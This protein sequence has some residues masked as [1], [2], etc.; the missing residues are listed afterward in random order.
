MLGFGIAAFGAAIRTGASWWDQPRSPRLTVLSHEEA[1]IFRS[2]ADTIFPGE[3]FPGGMPPAS[4]VGIVEFW[5][6]Y[7]A[8]VDTQTQR[9]L[10]LLT[11]AVDDGARL[12]DSRGLR[13]RDRPQAEREEILRAWDHSWFSAR[14][15][16]FT[17]LELFV[18]MGYTENP[19]VLEACGIEFMCATEPRSHASEP[20]G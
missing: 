1:E 18:A 7:L 19:R 20:I 3:K 16:A 4:E 15:G 17:S 6:G 2:I 12:A 10:R 8:S 5:D 13:F 9:L 14:R 11:H